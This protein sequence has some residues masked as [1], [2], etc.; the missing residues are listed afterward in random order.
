MQGMRCKGSHTMT[1][2][3][4][5][6]DC[7]ILEKYRL[8]RFCTHFEDMLSNSFLYLD[9]GNELKIHCA[10]AWLVDWILSDLDRLASHA[11]TI[12]GADSLSIYY[13]QEEIY[14]VPTHR[15]SSNSSS[16]FTVAS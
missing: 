8:E 14:T 1:F 13:A 3:I 10:E 15:F 11:W 4:T 2:N 16:D 6:N 5:R 9:R 12:I 7:L